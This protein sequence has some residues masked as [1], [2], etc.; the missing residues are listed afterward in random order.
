[1]QDGKMHQ[2]TVRFSPD[3]WESLEIECRRLGVSA[4]QFLREAAMARLAFTAG[5]RGDIA[6]E[7]AYADRGASRAESLEHEFAGLH[8]GE[9]LREATESQHAASAVSAQ[10]AQVLRR[11]QELRIHSAELRRQRKQYWQG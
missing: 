8:A 11:A 4:A 5:Q 9:A 3:L 2:T 6:Y 7:T 1:M 10:S